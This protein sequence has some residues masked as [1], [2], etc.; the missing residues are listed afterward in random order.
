MRLKVAL[1]GA[2]IA[3]LPLPTAAALAQT[4]PGIV[5]NTS[6]V[7]IQE[8][9]A[10]MT[11]AQQSIGRGD[12]NALLAALD[13]L[14]PRMAES[15][16]RTIVQRMRMP[17]LGAVG[18][19][20]DLP[21]VQ[22]ELAKAMPRDGLVKA[23]GV[24]IAADENRFVDA[25]DQISVLADSSPDALQ[26]ITGTAV[27]AISA[28]LTEQKAIAARGRMLISLAK[29]DWQPADQPDLRASFAAGAIE[30]LVTQDRT[31]EAETLLERIEQPESLA[32]MAVDRHFIK[33][34]PAIEGL[35]GPASGTAVDQFAR[36]RLAVYAESDQSPA[37]L[38]DAANA[39]LLLHRY[40]DVLDLT[41]D[42]KIA[43]GIGRDDVQTILY[44]ARALTVLGRRDDA[45]AL[46]S[47]FMKVD[48]RTA[49]D[50]ST[51]LVTYAEFLDEA[52]R[53]EEALAV[54]RATR[55][56]AAEVLS[57]Y[58]KRWIDR[59]EVCALS[60]LGRTAEA[61]TA[62]AALTKLSSQNEPAVIEAMLCAK[63]DA[64]AAQLAT[65]A[66]ADEDVASN[67][68]LQFQPAGST[69]APMP[70]RLRNLWLAFLARPDVKAAFD[71][72]G[73]VLPRDY[74]PDAK[75]RAI[76]RRSARGSDLT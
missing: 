44:R 10:A 12:C 1:L 6:G 9:E 39:M 31:P 11:V 40:Q 16:Q 47:G 17:C 68:L 26:I 2:A 75:P 42:V 14:V 58:G 52:G 54:V 55:Q 33:L 76:P 74:W 46:L 73:R 7:P 23:F 57:D 15:P 19:T 48:P 43:P 41:K 21:G 28:K 38:S 24:L 64:E 25:A 3:L 66:F 63:R 50:I 61:T 20:A 5:D 22:R 4:A 70:S 32:S 37:A 35:L 53:E 8:L 65:K 72:H 59:T 62:L 60:A 67:L 71:R 29:A 69:F 49:P 30:A 45:A 51:G 18:R 13:P 27:R 34:W 36:N 56:N